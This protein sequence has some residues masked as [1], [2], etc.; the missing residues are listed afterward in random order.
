MSDWSSW[1]Q[2]NP[3]VAVVAIVFG[4][5]LAIGAL[6]LLLVPVFILAEANAL[7]GFAAFFVLVVMSGFGIQQFRSDSE[8]EETDTAD[9]ITE[10]EQRY[11][12]GELS[13]GAFE[14]RLDKIIETE[15]E[16]D[17]TEPDHGRSRSHEVDTEKQ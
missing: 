14:H 13:D 15:E 2:E 16:I 3:V 5:A 12:R 9:P 10:L 11:V 1:V 17:R 8:T 6:S 7:L 4:G